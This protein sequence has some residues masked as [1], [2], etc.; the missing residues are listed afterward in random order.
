MTRHAESGEKHFFF[1]VENLEEKSDG[2]TWQISYDFMIFH[3]LA[4][5]FSYFLERLWTWD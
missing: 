2:Q 1:K 3:V 4:V 5:E